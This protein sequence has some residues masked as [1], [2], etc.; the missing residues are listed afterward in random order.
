MAIHVHGKSGHL[1][2]HSQRVQ[3]Q[4]RFLLLPKGSTWVEPSETCCAC[5]N[6]KKQQSRQYLYIQVF[7]Q[8]ALVSHVSGGEN[9]NNYEFLIFHVQ[10]YIYSWRGVTVVAYVKPA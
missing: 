10:S 8:T 1:G 5:L 3:I 4:I 7:T 6:T 9:I 2:L